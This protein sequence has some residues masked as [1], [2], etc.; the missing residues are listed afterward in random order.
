MP[1]WSDFIHPSVFVFYYLQL[2]IENIY[3][4]TVLGRIYLFFSFQASQLYFFKETVLFKKIIDL[5]FSA[6]GLR[7]YMQAFPSCRER[8]LLFAAMCGLPIAVAS[9]A[10]EHRCPGLS[11]CCMQGQKLWLSGLVAP[12]HMES[13]QT[14]DRT[15]VPCIGRQILFHYTAREVPS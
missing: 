4:S 9:L 13:S 10:V 2:I 14:R 15:C 6:L 3:I 5:L 11:S 1:I 8:G 7:C 12:R